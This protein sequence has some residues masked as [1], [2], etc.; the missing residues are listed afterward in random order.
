MSVQVGGKKLALKRRENGYLGLE[1][2]LLGLF[3]IN[4]GKLSQAAFTRAKIA[5]REVLLAGDVGGFA[6]VGEK[7][8]PKPIPAAWQARLGSYAYV[9][10]DALIATQIL[11]VRLKIENDFLLAEVIGKEGPGISALEPISDSEAI[12]RGLG[13]GLGETV[14]VRQT[15][16]GET[17]HFSGLVFK[18]KSTLENRD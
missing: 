16:D 9:G 2:R 11:G 6:L 4:L 15:G 1:Y 3:P 10:N 12:L 13:R 5:D 17:L 8:E 18:R 14:H 7:I